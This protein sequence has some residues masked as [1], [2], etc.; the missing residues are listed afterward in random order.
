MKFGIRFFFI[1][2]SFHLRCE[3]RHREILFTKKRE[4]VFIENHRAQIRKQQVYEI[5]K[6]YEIT[7]R[8]TICYLM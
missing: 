7:L 4:T 8:K 6:N 2:F 3:F 5:T 1:F